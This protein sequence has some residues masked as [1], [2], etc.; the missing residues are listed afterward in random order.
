MTEI[1]QKQI[2]T[3]TAQIIV[4]TS[5]NDVLKQQIDRYDNYVN[6]LLKHKLPINHINNTDRVPLMRIFKENLND[7]SR[8]DIC[9]TLES[10]PCCEKFANVI[11]SAIYEGKIVPSIKSAGKNFTYLD[12]NKNMVTVINT[13]FADCLCKA[14]LDVFQPIAKELHFHYEEDVLGDNSICTDSQMDI[15][16][17]KDDNRHNNIMLIKEGPE[18]LKIIKLIA[19]RVRVK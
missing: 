2:D 5:Q 6:I 1:L 19:S 12:D 7:M 11:E 10:D 3:L 14:L 15:E 13:K 16:T 18:R 9:K 17:Q 4:L 8:E